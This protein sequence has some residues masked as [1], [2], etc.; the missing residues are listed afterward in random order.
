[1]P[2]ESVL[3]DELVRQLI[4]IGEVDLLVGVPTFN[5]A[6]TVGQVVQAIRAGLVKYFPRDRSVVINPDGGS[7][8]GTADLV[9]AASINDLRHADVRALRTLHC[10]SS[11]Y[12]GD[13]STATALRTILA[14]A[15]LLRAKA[16]VVI[17]PDSTFIVPEWI[18][19]LLTPV[20]SGQTD[21]VTPRYQRHKF[22]ALLMTNLVYP[23]TRALYGKRVREPY[24]SEFALNGSLVGYFLGH[25]VWNQEAGRLG[26]EISLT[27]AAMAGNY[28]ITESVL[29][30]KGPPSRGHA[31]LVPA[32]RQTVG[33]L[34]AS[35]EGNFPVWRANGASQPVPVLGGESE[36][37]LDPVR[38]DRK[39]LRQMFSSGVEELE[40]VLKSILAPETLRELQ[41]IVRL[42]ESETAYPDE[43]WVRSVYE[44]AASYH[45]SVI[46]RD[47]IIQA[48]AP[49]YR[50]K[51]FTFLV[52]NRE[53]SADEV[54][55]NVENLCAAFEKQKPYL[56]ELWNGRE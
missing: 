44:F 31:D 26:S 16:C 35:L 34:F 32:I 8:D 47:H 2:E 19:R 50:G 53:A 39:R 30:P 13:P 24:A 6:R 14:S 10:I 54:A 33:P 20:Y 27:I 42:E 12:P 18:Q 40:P 3:T 37:T 5:H 1:V 17:A 11:R 38:V 55:V 28:R 41:R 43:L 36:M 29:G 49:L 48:L 9:S 56:V 4:N 15:D 23:M 7:S 52:Q 21:F 51:A 45:K 22:D 46:S 25:P